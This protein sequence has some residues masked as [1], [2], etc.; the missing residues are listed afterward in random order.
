MDT[1]TLVIVLLVLVLLFGGGS[2]YYGRRAR[3]RGPHYGGSLLGLILLI[4]LVLWLT[5]NL[6]GRRRLGPRV[7]VD[8]FSDG[9]RKHAYLPEV[10]A[11]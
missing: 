1:T 3:W 4:L 2:G 6:G 7:Q 10:R 11:S 5:G 8:R 9:A